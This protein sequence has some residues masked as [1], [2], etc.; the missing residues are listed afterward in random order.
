MSGP[1]YYPGM[2][3]S[4]P[5]EDLTGK[6]GAW[7]VAPPV[8]PGFQREVWQRIAAREAGREEAIWPVQARPERL[9]ASDDP[10]GLSPREDPV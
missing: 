2:N 1:V 4:E 6:L 3:H 5:E 9:G 8:P 7:K 10:L